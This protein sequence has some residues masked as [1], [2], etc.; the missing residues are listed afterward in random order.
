VGDREEGSG[1]LSME[2]QIL[3]NKK[4]G[5]GRALRAKSD[6]GDRAGEQREERG[7]GREES[8]SKERGEGKAG[9]ERE[10]WRRE[11]KRD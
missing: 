10:R 7:P 6:L 11:T 3:E 1:Y 5:K 9:K 4:R 2:L 8:G